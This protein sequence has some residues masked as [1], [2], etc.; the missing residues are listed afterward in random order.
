MLYL[1]LSQ[2]D[3]PFLLGQNLR[4]RDLFC[5]GFGYLLPSCC[6]VGKKQVERRRQ[7]FRSRQSISAPTRSRQDLRDFL[8]ALLPNKVVLLTLPK[9]IS[10]TVSNPDTFLIQL[11]TFII[12]DSFLPARNGDGC[13]RDEHEQPGDGLEPHRFRHGTS[14]KQESSVHNFIY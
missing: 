5:I 2:M 3:I 4:C 9:W 6:D 14:K 11:S 1:I 8:L 12:S 13:W 10:T 7:V